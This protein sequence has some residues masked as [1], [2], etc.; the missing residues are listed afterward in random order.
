MEPPMSARLLF[1][2]ALRILGMWYV[3]ASIVGLAS[4]VASWQLIA[5]SIGGQNVG[6]Y[7]L[8]EALILAVQLAMSVALIRWAPAIAARF[9]PADSSLPDAE[10]PES[11]LRV[12]PGDVYHTACFVLGA[13][14]LVQGVKSA[15]EMTIGAVSFGSQANQLARAAVIAI[16]DTASGLL[17][18]FGSRGI[19]QFL[20][21]LRYDPDS[22]PRQQFS[23]KL[24]LIITFIVAV[25]LGV[26]RMITVGG[27]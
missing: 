9:Y 3:F 26:I 4:T 27:L 11:R 18:I 15:G 19:A 5:G 1:E 22:I 21:N 16:V 24:L 7:V 2:V 25:I 12:G 23:I 20:S 17:L 6:G 10:N 14:L 8:L 13:Y